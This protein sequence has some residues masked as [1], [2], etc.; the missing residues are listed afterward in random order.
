MILELK[1]VSK[2]FDNTFVLENVN[3]T[4]ESGKIYGLLG[5]NG[6]GKSVLLKLIC[7]FYDVTSGEILLD[8]YNYSLNNEFLKDA[9]CLIEKPSFLPDLTG[10]EN[11]KLLAQVQNRIGDKEILKALEDVNLSL[12][13][14]KK[15]S[16]Y[17]LGTKQKL[18]IAQ[19]LMENPKII[20]LDEPTNGIEDKTAT[21]I[22]N[23]LKEEKKKDKIIIIASHIKEEI[24][25]LADITYKISS[26]KVT[27]VK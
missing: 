26:G 11:L 19:V 8:G 2:K 12:E 14:D 20:I 9:R 6:S 7:G 27:K 4:F 25:L 23:L 24:E 15:Y 18:G 1:N 3:L 21:D 13:K 5:N 17:S 10:Y 22:R 16:K